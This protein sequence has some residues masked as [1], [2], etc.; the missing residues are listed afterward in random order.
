[1]H[2][3]ETG[4]GG[5]G[6][7]L[8]A[9]APVR[10][11]AEGD[12]ILEVRGLVKHYLLTRGVLFKKQVGAVKAVDGVDFDLRPA[13]RSASWA[14]PAAASRPSARCCVHLDPPTGGAIRFG[15]RSSPRCRAGPARRMR[16]NIQMVFQDPYTR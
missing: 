5:G 8:Q 4:P 3:D 6:S 9:E 10:P 15:A 11:Y 1:M 12:P 7:T 13:R 14:S 2:A 16:R